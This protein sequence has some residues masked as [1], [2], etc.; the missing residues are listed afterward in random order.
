MTDTAQPGTAAPAAAP[1]PGTPAHDAAMVAKADAAGA[2]AVAAAAPAA[3]APTA[4]QRPDYIP[5]KFWDA[6]K[7]VVKAEEMAKSYAELEKKQ[8]Q[9]QPI[10]DPKAVES[11]IAA[12]GLNIDEFAQ[13]FAKSGKLSDESYKKLDGAGVPKATVDAY[14]AG[15]QAIAE[16]M[17]NEAYAV[18]GG[19]DQY[20]AMIKWAG[21]SMTQDEIAAFDKAVT[22]GDSNAMRLAIEGLKARY[23]AANGSDP[24]LVNGTG[25]GSQTGDVFRSWNEVTVAMQDTRYGRDPAYTQDLMNKLN[26]SELGNAGTK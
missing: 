14:I 22:S 5:E 4:A 24:K 23:V 18:V 1:T 9:P 15:Q 20:A 7:G 25:D 11:T 2:A 26:R 3:P 8:S 6:A 17:A 10:T 12:K 16:K 13:E 19:K 21:A